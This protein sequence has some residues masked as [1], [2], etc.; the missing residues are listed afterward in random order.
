M[1]KAVLDLSHCKYIYEIHRNIK[2]ALAL[3]DYYGSNLSALWD[4][5]NRDCEFD[6]ISISGLSTLPEELIEYMDR[7]LEILERNKNYWANS[8]TPFDYEIK[9]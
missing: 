5:I 8:S 4:C 9:E 2:E 7:V 6:F 1:K 3:P